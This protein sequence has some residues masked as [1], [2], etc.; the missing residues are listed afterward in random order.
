MAQNRRAS[1][2]HLVP[3]VSGSGRVLGSAGNRCAAAIKARAARSTCP[4]AAAAVS[5][6]EAEQGAPLRAT[7]AAVVR[8]S[9]T[10]IAR[11]TTSN[12]TLVGVTPAPAHAAIATIRAAIDTG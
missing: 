4:T 6:V 8:A 7:V 2:G 10:W 5:R 9:R 12:A 11:A 3:R 1:N